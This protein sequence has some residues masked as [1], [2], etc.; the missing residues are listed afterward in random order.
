MCVTV[1]SC[2]CDMNVIELAKGGLTDECHKMV[3]Q[4]SDNQEIKQQV[5][6]CKKED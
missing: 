6:I 2:D 1:L 3:F 4:K 5:K